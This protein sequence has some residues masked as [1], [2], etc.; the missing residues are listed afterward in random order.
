MG[1]LC[2]FSSVCVFHHLMYAEGR[3]L[4][5]GHSIHDFAASVDAIASRKIMGI[6]RL[7]GL[8]INNNAAILQ[9]KLRDLLKEFQ[10]ALLAQ[11]LDHHFYIQAKFGPVKVP[12]LT[13][14]AAGARAVGRLDAAERLADL[15]AKV[16]GI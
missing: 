13:E 16:A 11:R 15:V 10:L 7:H 6:F 3:L 2:C 9:F 12:R 14:M 1:C 4:A 5:V 8:R